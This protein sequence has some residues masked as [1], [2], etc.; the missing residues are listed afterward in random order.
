[1]IQQLVFESWTDAMALHVCRNMRPNDFKEIFAQ[2]ADDDPW[3]LYRDMASMGPAHLWLEIARAADTAVPIALFGVMQVSPGVGVAHLMGTKGLTV[4]AA[5]Q[6]SA[7]IR[8]YVIPAMLE[9]GLHRVEAHSLAE[10][11]WAHRFLRSTGAVCEGIRTAVG[12]DGEDFAC[13]IWLKSTIEN[14]PEQRK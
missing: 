8:E 10:Y 9:A 7:R 5:A 2:R 11:R 13:F 6:I 4:H 3:A 14:Q 12:R 1:M